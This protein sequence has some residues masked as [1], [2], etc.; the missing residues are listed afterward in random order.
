MEVTLVLAGIVLSGTGIGM[1][2][3]GVTHGH[4]STFVTGTVCFLFG[5]GVAVSSLFV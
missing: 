3:S 2:Q 4:A 5:V 1:V